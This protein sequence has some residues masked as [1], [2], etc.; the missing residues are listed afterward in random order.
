MQDS[1]HSLHIVDVRDRTRHE[2][3]LVLLLY[4]H[5]HWLHVV[6]RSNSRT[7][8]TPAWKHLRG[9]RAICTSHVDHIRWRHCILQALNYLI[10]YALYRLHILSLPLT[11]RVLLLF[12]EEYKY[13]RSF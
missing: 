13:L 3:G 12:G 4:R 8:V 9:H 11:G 10:D 5:Q 7:Q 2:I 6:V 1:L